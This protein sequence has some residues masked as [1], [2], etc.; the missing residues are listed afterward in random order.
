MSLRRKI[1]FKDGILLVSLLL[2]IAG[3][4]WGLH[5]QRQHVEAS[6]NEYAALQRVEKAESRLVAFQQAV[7]SGEMKQP[8]AITDLRAALS[9]MS[10]YKAVISQ[11]D[12]TLP[13]EITSDLQSSVKAKTKR[14]VSGLVQI[15]MQLAPPN[16]H[17]VVSGEAPAEGAAPLNQAQIAAAVDELSREL[18]DLLVMCNGFVHRTQLESD[19]DLRLATAAVSSIAA[20][21]LLLAV[22]GSFWHYRKIVVPLQRLRLWCRRTAGGD[23]SIPYTPTSDREFQELGRDVNQMADELNAF[24]RRLEAMVAAK[25]RELAQSERLASVG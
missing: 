20:V 22:A 18:A 9:A 24:Y 3:A 11:Y 10:E 2:M 15:T 19:A 17:R 14:I 5:R 25:S 16:S 12:N 13:P 7:D 23:F 21:I 8:Q 1:L 4:L 6:L